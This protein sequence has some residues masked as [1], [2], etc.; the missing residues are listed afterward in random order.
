MAAT[1]I[2]VGTDLSDSSERAIEATGEYARAHGSKVSLVHVV[3]PR[4]F[5]PPQAV[6]QGGFE[7]ESAKEIEAELDRLRET[8]LSG[9]DSTSVLLVDHSPARAICDYAKDHGIDAI[10]VGSHGHG[11]IEAWLIGSVAERVVRHA[12][13][14]VFVFR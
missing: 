13:C 2:L 10:A 9:L 6:L 3:D 5:V 4:P 8:L 12:H 11:R 1:H 7:S 14:T